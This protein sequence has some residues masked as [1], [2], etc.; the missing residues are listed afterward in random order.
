MSLNIIANTD[1]LDIAKQYMTLISDEEKIAKADMKKFLDKTNLSSEEKTK[2]YSEFSANLFTLKIQNGLSLAVNVVTQ[3][4]QLDLQDQQNSAQIDLINAQKDVQEQ[5]K[6][7]AEQTVKLETQKVKLA[8]QEEKINVSKVW[9]ENAKAEVMFDQTVAGTIT[10]ARKNGAEITPSTK[11]YTCPV[12][13][14]NISYGHLSLVACAS[15]DTTKGLI[16]M[17]MEQLKEQAGTFKNH[18]ALQ[19]GNQVM[20]LAST[21]LSE[22][23]TKIDGLLETHKTI[24]DDVVGSNVTH[25]NYATIS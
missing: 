11:F 2:R 24:I 25:S 10:E 20:Q 3:D 1:I 15:T 14:Q 22:G 17:Q 12:T 5:N 7:V 4:K 23:L 18:T 21:A 8:E 6:L 9:L 19:A 16:G 13:N